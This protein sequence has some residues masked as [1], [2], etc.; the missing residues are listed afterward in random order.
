[1]HLQTHSQYDGGQLRGRGWFM[2]GLEPVRGRGV[3]GIYTGSL[4]P[5]NTCF[6]KAPF[7]HAVKRI[8]SQWEMRTLTGTWTWLHSARPCRA[9]WAVTFHIWAALFTS[10]PDT[11]MHHGRAVGKV[12]LGQS[13]MCL[14]TWQQPRPFPLRTTHLI[15]TPTPEGTGRVF[16]PGPDYIFCL[17]TCRCGK[18]RCRGEENSHS[19]NFRQ[20]LHK[21]AKGVS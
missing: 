11:P 16:L 18:D 6:L 10:S 20:I 7:L 17:L 14:K 9:L 13:I 15:D 5:S 19:S 4:A 21:M 12:W 1:M 8:S 2:G 3:Q